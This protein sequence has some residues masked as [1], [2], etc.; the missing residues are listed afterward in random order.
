MRLAARAM[1][2]GQRLLITGTPETLEALDKALWVDDPASFL[3]HALAG[4]EHDA[5]QPILLSQTAEAANGA[6]LLML[7]ES[8]LPALFDRYDRVLNLFNDGGDAHIRARAD[9]KAIG[10]RDGVSRT[11][12]QQNERGRWERMA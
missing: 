4:G 5:D 12:W 10:G 3:P 6:R 11:Y 8:G 1:E 7:V 9:W 2:S